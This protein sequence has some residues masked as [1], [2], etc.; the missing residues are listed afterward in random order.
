MMNVVVIGGDSK[1]VTG[2]KDG[3]TQYNP[4]LK[5]TEAVT[6]GQALAH[7]N[8]RG[9]CDVIL[10]DA[11]TPRADSM[12]LV[13]A[14]RKSRRPV[15]I[16]VLLDATEKDPPSEE[17]KAG[18]DQFVMKRAGIGA[19]IGESLQQA[20]DRRASEFHPAGRRVRLLY[21]GDIEEARRHL[22]AM[23]YVVLEQL[24]L[25]SGG[26]QLP[27]SG[28][29]PGDLV[30]L[31]HATT[32]EHTFS[33][34]KEI[35][36][37]APE[38]PIILLTEP[39]DEDTPVQAIRIGAADCIAKTASCF[40]RLLPAVERE[41]R[42]RELARETKALKSRGERLR[43][44][45]EA[46]PVGVTL[47]APDGTFLAV[48][49]TG[50]QLIGAKRI[51]QVIGKNILQ[52]V[53]R[54]EREKVHSFLTTVSGW[55]NASIRLDWK[56]FDGSVPGIELQAIPMRREGGGAAAALTTIH[57]P[58]SQ[59]KDLT[60][61]EEI[62]KR[63]DDL[64]KTLRAY[65]V[66]F[67]ELQEKNNLKQSK[68]EAA[69]QETEAR[70]QAAEEQNV[71]LKEASEENASRIA[72]LIEEHRT[73]R[74]GWELS[75]QSFK[76]QCVKIEA[77]A[78][79]LRSAQASLL[80]KQKVEQEHWEQ[81][82]RELEEKLE[83]AEA[84]LTQLSA[85]SA[86][87]RH[88]L[89]RDLQEMREQY[90]AVEEQR[91]A[92]E[93]ILHEA[94]SKI[95]M[96]VEAHSVERQH[97]DSAY[98]DL[99]EKIRS[100][101]EQYNLT[102]EELEKAEE[103][104][105]RQ[106]EQHEAD[107]ALLDATVHE[108][109]SK[110]QDA[111]NRLPSMESALRHAEDRISQ[112]TV[113]RDTQQGQLEQTRKELEQKAVEA[114]QRQSAMENLLRET[115]TRLSQ[116]EEDHKK[117]LDQS[118][119]A[120]LQ[121]EQQYRAAEE[122]RDSIRE[123]LLL[124]EGQ[125]AK[126]SEEVS[127]ERSAW[128]AR[129]NDLEQKLKFAEQTSVDFREALEQAEAILKQQSGG[130][131]DDIS[132]LE[133]RNREL[134]ARCQ[135]AEEQRRSLMD[136][137]DKE[138]TGRE[139]QHTTLQIERTEWEQKKQELEQACLAEETNRETMQAALLQA[140][141]HLSDILEKH[142]AERGKQ[143]LERQ[144]LHKKLEDAENLRADL[145][146]ALRKAE[147]GHM[148]LEERH[149]EELARQEAT[150]R[151]MEQ[152]LLASE[153]R[154]A[155]LGVILRETENLL[156]AL[157]EQQESERS[158]LETAI[159][160][161]ERKHQESEK[162]RISLQ[163]A[164]S[165]ANS[166]LSQLNDKHDAELS[167]RDLVGKELELKLQVAEKQR[168]ALQNAFNEAESS[169]AQ[170][171]EKQRTEVS[172]YEF[173]LKKAEQKYQ[174]IEKQRNILQ[175][176]HDVLV[177]NHS[178]IKDKYT[179]DRSQWDIVRSELEQKLQ[180]TE[181]EHAAALQN[182]V[183]DAESRL[184]W[185]SEQNQA[186]ALQLET[187]QKELAYLQT[188]HRKLTTESTDYRLRFQ[189]LSQ[190]T[191]AGILLTSRDGLVLECNDTAAQMFG[192]MNADEALST[193]GEPR[194]RLYAFEG[195]LFNRLEQDGKLEN[196][197]WSTLD[198][199]GRLVR[200][201]EFA[202]LVESAD[203]SMIVERILTDITRTHKLSEEIRRARR[204]ESTG[205]LATVTVKSFK[206]LCAA[207][208]QSGESLMESADDAKNVRRL[209]E[210]LLNDA[211]RGVKHARQFLS[212]AQKAD[213]E[214]ALL[215]LNDILKN[216]NPLLHSLIG[217]DIDLQTI[218]APRIG[219]VSADQ[220]ELVQLIGNL[221][222]NSREALPLGG[223]VTIETSN[224]EVDSHA[225]EHPASLHPGIYARMM[226]S[227][228]GCAVQPER[229]N[230]SIRSLVERLGGYLE[231]INDPKLGNIHKVYLPRVEA[232]SDQSDLMA[233]T[234]GA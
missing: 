216:N 39:E 126:Q 83:A 75:R 89:N 69:L 141:A 44:I 68:W 197:E 136:E 212:V 185:I 152:R 205:D 163:S 183:R 23:P 220:N 21:A 31:D 144:E 93:S 9:T 186:K 189:R 90:D 201:Q 161:H 97:L 226:F 20:R 223:V 61:D 29:T 10:I 28:T 96:Q 106:I 43:Q 206:D 124:V 210:S 111:E 200:F 120:R 94:G 199:A 30:I 18:V 113:E 168:N 2:L 160:E 150:L 81:Q 231:T 234:V 45:V 33:A 16:V 72:S 172:Q 198:R 107:R 190:F 32:G 191:A 221:L 60:T 11:S 170:L 64:T 109:S 73:Q 114:D 122:Q 27:E 166:R 139:L 80:E 53:P 121:L 58:G 128:D 135:A 133:S 6:T 175:A 37:R 149:N 218:L 177:T 142:N 184:A 17:F 102:R 131:S 86:S 192:Y 46:M 52:L 77:V 84:S 229:R 103:R 14:I 194:F 225:S 230:A 207:L 55:A 48:N 40:K 164:L 217:E 104:V 211:N 42:A 119:S 233:N 66:R 56:G 143:E 105:A 174:A 118:S 92:L 50:L 129:L 188:E 99:Q 15:G 78:E 148:T 98:R 137:L 196:I 34:I 140:E 180:A 153:K 134:E 156:A 214:P 71:L 224:I 101:E 178:Q 117:T 165:E 145:Q 8:T 54:E 76:E 130:S 167:Q 62:K 176:E 158:R 74:S 115:E 155:D 147:S 213:R 59:S 1:E 232:P 79:S 159:R 169:L 12:E 5:I 19:T 182:A 157:T 47:I 24:P 65:E 204:M 171:A 173:T 162:L 38:I 208:A 151:E 100:T 3:L 125:L 91:S 112:L 195:A 203:D 63:C 85:T 154:H 35:L 219:M 7:I 49:R 222:A 26:I 25:T 36:A 4:A 13:A 123:K 202:T 181:K 51:D 87:E 108:L 228:D 22:S 227:T 215:N 70:C 41:I 179:T 82:R 95:T 116:L 193:T 57:P 127:S 67:R 88:H 209:A 187:A 146:Q 110:L 132:R 138:R